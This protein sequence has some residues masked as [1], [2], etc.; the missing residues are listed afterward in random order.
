[1]SAQA[2]KFAQHG[3]ESGHWWT[4]DGRLVH[5][6]PKADGKGYTK[7]TLVHARKMLLLPGVTTPLDIIEKP[8]LTNWRIDQ[9]I[10]AALTLPRKPGESE[11]D[12]LDRV[13]ED[14]KETARKAAARGTEIHKAVQRYYDIGHMP[15][16]PA[17]VKSVEGVKR[18]LRNT[19]GEQAWCAERSLVCNLGFAS[20]SDLCCPEYVLDFKGKEGAEAELFGEKLYDEHFMQLSATRYGLGPDFRAAKCGIVFVSRDVPGDCAFVSATEDDLVRGWEML[21]RKSVV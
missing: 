9:A 5:Q 16:E 10:L 15:D 11:K 6:V 12:W 8:G 21:D 1:M 3:S 14:A 17:L 13:K 4:R 18:L 20:K 2:P 7:P 19:C